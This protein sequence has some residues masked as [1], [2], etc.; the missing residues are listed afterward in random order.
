MWTISWIV[1][2]RLW[3]WFSGREEKNR[4]ST[5]QC[6]AAKPFR[7]PDVTLQTIFYN[8]ETRLPQIIPTHQQFRKKGATSNSSHKWY[9]RSIP[10][11]IRD[12]NETVQVENCTGGN[13]WTG[14]DVA[15][16][17][18]KE[19]GNNWKGEGNLFWSCHCVRHYSHLLVR[20]ILWPWKLSLL[21]TMLQSIR[22]WWDGPKINKYGSISTLQKQRI[23]V[24]GR[25]RTTY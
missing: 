21:R 24:N 11:I 2:K 20:Y 18:R 14:N 13:L 7:Y 4:V 8:G 3:P 22:P 25:N 16:S 19:H 17:H 23:A 12:D 6:A 10:H 15:S 5:T 1:R 9:Q